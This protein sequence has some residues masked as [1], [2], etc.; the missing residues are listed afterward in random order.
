MSQQSN[1]I[2]RASALHTPLSTTVFYAACGSGPLGAP[3]RKKAHGSR[4]QAA[5]QPHWRCCCPALPR[6]A[7]TSHD[8][9]VSLH[10]VHLAA[11]LISLVSDVCSSEVLYREE[12][13]LTSYLHFDLTLF[14]GRRRENPARSREACLTLIRSTNNLQILERVFTRCLDSTAETRFVGPQ[15]HTTPHGP[16]DHCCQNQSVKENKDGCQRSLSPIYRRGASIYQC[17]IYLLYFK[18]SWFPL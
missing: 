12:A 17:L 6:T 10:H 13:R 14:S 7:R 9:L 8:R 15:S 1:T 18:Q 3:T 2:Y 11:C 4:A 5:H 16:R